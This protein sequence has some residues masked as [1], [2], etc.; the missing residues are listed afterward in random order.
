MQGA[1]GQKAWIVV[2]DDLE[3]DDGYVN[4]GTVERTKESQNALAHT[5]P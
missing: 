5:E 4:Q 2:D 3:R 1:A